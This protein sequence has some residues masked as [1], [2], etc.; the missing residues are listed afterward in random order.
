MAH[1]S[2]FRNAKDFTF[3]TVSDS[4]GDWTVN[5]TGT[6]NL[7]GA[8]QVVALTYT[9]NDIFGALS[10]VPVI[11]VEHVSN[12]LEGFGNTGVNVS[13]TLLDSH[14][15]TKGQGSSGN[16]PYGSFSAGLFDSNG[17]P[18]YP[19]GGDVVQSSL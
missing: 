19:V 18:A 5:T 6:V 13:F 9:G 3:D 12:V 11:L 15:T 10:D 7:I 14:G 8:D 17:D 4:N 16:M 2:A 1:H